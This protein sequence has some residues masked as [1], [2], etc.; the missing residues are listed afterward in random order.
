MSTREI[1]RM[2]VVKQVLK[3]EITRVKAAKLLGLGAKQVSRLCAALSAMA[4]RGWSPAS[5]AG[6][7]TGR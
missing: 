5:A 4:P 2:G 6:R 3:R 1:D 7:A